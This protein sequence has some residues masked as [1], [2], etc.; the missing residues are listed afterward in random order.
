MAPIHLI[1]CIAFVLSIGNAAARL[2]DKSIQHYEVA[3]WHHETTFLY[4]KQIQTAN[5]SQQCQI[6]LNRMF[7][8]NNTS[9]ETALGRQNW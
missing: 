7:Q 9:I 8:Q 2:V 5:A 3:E 4:K 1:T 6:D